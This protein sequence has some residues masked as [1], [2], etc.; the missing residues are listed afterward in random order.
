MKLKHLENYL[1]FM[2]AVQGCE[3]EVYFNSA[4]GDHLNLRSTFCQYLF[5]AACGDRDFLTQGEILC[6]RESDYEKLAAFLTEE[7]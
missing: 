6:A 7:A 1:E 3:G 5:A 4:E 2:E